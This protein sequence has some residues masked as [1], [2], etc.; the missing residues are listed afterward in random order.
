MSINLLS[1]SGA[2][3]LQYPHHTKWDGGKVHIVT[4]PDQKINV[5]DEIFV[6]FESKDN[7]GD[8]SYAY[9]HRPAIVTEVLEHRSARGEHPVD[10]KPVFQLLSIV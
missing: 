1:P 9:V 5:G 3:P 7:K 6:A 10:F 2:K 8:I 4:H